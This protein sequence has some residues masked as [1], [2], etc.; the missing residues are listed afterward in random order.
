M[1]TFAGTA[2]SHA[3]VEAHKSIA[4]ELKMLKFNQTIAKMEEQLK[5]KSSV[6]S[7]VKDILEKNKKKK[8]L[9]S[10]AGEDIDNSQIAAKEGIKAA[11]QQ[12]RINDIAGA[13]IDD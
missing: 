5:L 12:K 8:L 4:E 9:E 13:E 2:V 11:L 10:M 3:N 7:S 1:S 6:S